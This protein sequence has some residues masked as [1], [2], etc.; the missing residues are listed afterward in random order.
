MDLPSWLTPSPATLP[1]SNAPPSPFP[2]YFELPVVAAKLTLAEQRRAIE[3]HTFEAIY[4]DALEHIAS[5]EHLRT[6]CTRDPRKPDYKRFIAWV[7]ESEERKNAYLNARAIGAEI[8]LTQIVEIADAADSPEEVD[9]SAL[10]ISAR[11]WVMGVDNRRRFGDVKQ[12]E[13][14]TQ[15]SVRAA[16]DAGQRR[17]IE[18]ADVV[19]NDDQRQLE[20]SDD[21][22]A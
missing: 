5:G 17:V 10:R 16:L 21:A 3:R 8:N 6:F 14:T 19:E 12:V 15:I 1:N 9:R 4:D 2:Q 22:V 11:K 13:M 18:M 7:H 20:D